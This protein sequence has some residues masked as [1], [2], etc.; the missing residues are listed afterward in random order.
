[1]RPQREDGLPMQTLPARPDGAGTLRALM[2][3]DVHHFVPPVEALCP[4][5]PD[6]CVEHVKPA[7]CRGATASY[8][9]PR[10]TVPARA[11]SAPPDGLRGSRLALL[12]EQV[13]GPL[14]VE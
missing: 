10:A 7:A 12:R 3:C 2:D 9:P 14:G 6:C 11:D 8:S 5:L 13:L 1:M 4:C